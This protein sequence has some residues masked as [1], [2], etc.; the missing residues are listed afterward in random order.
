MLVGAD[1]WVDVEV[2]T[3][4]IRG[5]TGTASNQDGFQMYAINDIEWGCGNIIEIN[6][7]SV[8]GNSVGFSIHLPESTG[9]TI[10][11]DDEVEGA[12][13]GVTNFGS[14]CNGP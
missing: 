2:D 5:N 13:R 8:N 14:G 4:L 11:C 1:S 7:A 3:Y 9:N 6:I 12:V 10:R